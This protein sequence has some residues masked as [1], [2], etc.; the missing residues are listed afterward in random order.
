MCLCGSGFGTFTLAP[1]S[2]LVLE[3]GGW[4]WVLRTLGLLSLLGLPCGAAMTPPGGRGGARGKQQEEEVQGG[5]ECE[6]P[7]D[8][9]YQ[10]S[11][12]ALCGSVVRLVLGGQLAASTRLLDY[13]LFAVTDFLCFTAVYIPYTHLPSFAQVDTSQYTRCGDAT[14]CRAAG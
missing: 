8:V 5:G 7:P 10:D 1:L 11:G 14:C 12:R 4:R 2:Q 3:G 13:A 6:H 9:L